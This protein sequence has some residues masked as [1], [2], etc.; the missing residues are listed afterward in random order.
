ML[1][2]VC[3]IAVS[4]AQVNY[5]AFNNFG[6][7]ATGSTSFTA[8]T[9]AGRHTHQHSVLQVYSGNTSKGN[10]S[11]EKVSSTGQTT[12]VSKTSYNLYAYL[13]YPQVINLK[14]AS[15]SPGIIPSGKYFNYYKNTS[16][17]FKSNL[18]VRVYNP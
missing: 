3:A 9:N 7:S 13:T 1:V 4:A 5:F 8:T 10:I 2:S 11:L 16:G 15:G 17:G 6:T 18:E 12:V 14:N